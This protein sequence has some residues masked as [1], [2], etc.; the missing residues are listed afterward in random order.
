M[1][2]TYFI[3]NYIRKFKVCYIVM[4]L[5]VSM[6]CLMISFAKSFLRKKF[7]RQMSKTTIK[8]F[9]LFPYAF[10]NPDTIMLLPIAYYT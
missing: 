10:M 8:Y 6:L 2:K 4:R 1:L 9:F 7:H 5:F 3:L